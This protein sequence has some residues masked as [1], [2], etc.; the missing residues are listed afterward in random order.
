MPSLNVSL[1]DFP[2]LSTST[3]LGLLI[4]FAAHESIPYLVLIF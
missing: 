2:V 4:K 3:A 1:V